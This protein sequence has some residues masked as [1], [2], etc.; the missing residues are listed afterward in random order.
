MSDVTYPN[1][2][3]GGN[4]VSLLDSYVRLREQRGRG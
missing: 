3:R 4:S 2:V 1:S